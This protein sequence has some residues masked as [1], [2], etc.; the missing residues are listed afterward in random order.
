MNKKLLKKIIATIIF[1]GFIVARSTYAE[2]ADIS[3]WEVVY[4]ESFT[5]VKAGE[6]PEDFFVLDGDLQVINQEGNKCLKLSGNPVGEHGFLY[7]PRLSSHSFEASFSCFGAEKSR[8]HNVFAGSLGGI[9]GHIFRINPVS[10]KLSLFYNELTIGEV[11][12]PSWSS[13]DWMKVCIRITGEGKKSKCEIFL[14]KKAGFHQTEK[15]SELLIE[16]KIKRGRFALWGFA[17]AEQD[18]Y[19]DDLIIRVPNFNGGAKAN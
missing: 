6:L 17:Y 8:R 9:R 4:Q 15:I 3:I 10:E 11:A 16:E 7:G 14:S 1:H 5:K 12:V 13:N 18:M 2:N 19:W